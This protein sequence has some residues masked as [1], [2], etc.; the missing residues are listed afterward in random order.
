MIPAVKRAR[1]SPA[2]E[3]GQQVSGNMH[4]ISY[5]RY[6]M[7]SGGAHALLIAG[8]LGFSMVHGCAH[9]PD[10][11][12]QHELSLEIPDLGQ[13][14]PTPTPAPTPAL[15]PVVKAD[16]QPEEPPV[17]APPDKED[18]VLPTPEKNKR[19]KPKKP[20]V[21]PDS[22]RKPDSKLKIEVNRTLVVR[23][24]PKPTTSRRP[25][26]TPE[27][28]AKAIRLGAHPGKTST[29]SDDDI[30][31]LINS[32]V[33]FGKGDPIT[34]D[35]A[36][37]DLVRQILYRAWDQPGS[38]GVIGLSARIELTVTPDG[39]ILSSRLVNGSGN[40]VMDNSVMQA[41]RSVP[42]LSGVPG[43]FLSRHRTL[44]IVFELTGGG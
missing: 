26:L 42:R 37:K 28:I 16:P 33:K 25:K 34:Q 9:P 36:Y 20:E 14:D 40:T 10:K 32:D 22:A 2:E 15:V 3:L 19:E 43:D 30:R 13:Q 31:T 5:T 8:L 18:I 39:R 41:V 38:L 6:I 7:A 4:G 29:L 27:E 11:G 24:L 23:G 1:M 12:N 21:K 17:V 35:A 44:P